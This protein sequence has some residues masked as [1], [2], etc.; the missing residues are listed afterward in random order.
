MSTFGG[1]GRLW[2]APLCAQL[3]A[4]FRAAPPA[5]LRAR[6][7]RLLL[8]GRIALGKGGVPNGTKGDAARVRLGAHLGAQPPEE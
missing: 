8:S 4:P 3:G 1:A 6:V 7:A 2:R 5:L